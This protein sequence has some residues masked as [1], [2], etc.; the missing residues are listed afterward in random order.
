M[1]ESGKL[2]TELPARTSLVRMATLLRWTPM[3]EAGYSLK[4]PSRPCGSLSLR[5]FV[6]V[7]LVSA[8]S[9]RS[10]LLVDLDRTAQHLGRADD[11]TNSQSVRSTGRVGRAHSL[12]DRLSDATVQKII[13]DFQDGIPRYKI[14][15]QYG[16]SVSSVAR[17]LRQWREHR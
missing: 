6:L 10:D 8:Y 4:I 11:A 9:K 2:S 1:I 3:S 16:I 5:L 15:K 13:L 12:Q 7:D 14:A 17:L